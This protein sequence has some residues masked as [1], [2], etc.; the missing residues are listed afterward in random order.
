[1]TNPTSRIPCDFSFCR[2]QRIREKESNFEQETRLKTKPPPQVRP[3][4]V[5]ARRDLPTFDCLEC[6]IFSKEKE[7]EKPPEKARAGTLVSVMQTRGSLP[8]GPQTAPAPACQTA[9]GSRG[10]AGHGS[11]QQQQTSARAEGRPVSSPV[12][13]PELRSPRVTAAELVVA[14]GQGPA[15]TRAQ[16]CRTPPARVSRAFT[17]TSSFVSLHPFRV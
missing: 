1:M 2:T 14:A 12:A 8:G 9:V 3:F 15:D 13:P 17:Q 16:L 6:P 7:G 10:I 5:W 11:K 4:T